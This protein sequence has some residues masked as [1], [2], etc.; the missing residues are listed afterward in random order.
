MIDI[1]HFCE[2]SFVILC[3]KFCGLPLIERLSIPLKV[4]KKEHQTHEYNAL[5]KKI[6]K[7][8]KIMV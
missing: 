2:F 4:E 3:S 8:K 1:N 6:E 7:K 5:D